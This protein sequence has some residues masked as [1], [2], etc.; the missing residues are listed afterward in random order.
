[1]I[2]FEFNWKEK[3]QLLPSVCMCL[4]RYYLVLSRGNVCLVLRQIE[5]IAIFIFQACCGD[6]NEVSSKQ[7]C[8]TLRRHK[9]RPPV[10]LSCRHIASRQ[11]EKQR[12]LGLLTVD[13]RDKTYSSALYRVRFSDPPSHASYQKSSFFIMKLCKGRKDDRYWEEETL[14]ICERLYRRGGIYNIFS[15]INML[16]IKRP[17]FFLISFAKEKDKFCLTCFKAFKLQNGYCVFSPGGCQCC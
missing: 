17:T 6:T 3:H 9:Q 2:Q 16:E 10:L 1:M 15:W 14:G 4:F 8:L 12:F 5:L 11:K 13:G 7:Q